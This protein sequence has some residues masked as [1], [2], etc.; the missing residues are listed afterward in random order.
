M[1]A[2]VVCRLAVHRTIPHVVV[3]VAYDS[4]SHGKPSIW[5]QRRHVDE[6]ATGVL[7]GKCQCVQLSP[8]KCCQLSTDRLLIHVE[9]NLE[10]LVLI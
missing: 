1:T 3:F 8:L 5:P 4:P 9:V 7:F 6:D 10:T 2:R